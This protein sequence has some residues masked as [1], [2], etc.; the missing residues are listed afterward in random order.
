MTCQTCMHW[1][2][3]NHPSM[4]KHGFGNCNLQE[5]KWVFFPLQHMCSSHKGASAEIVVKREAYFRGKQ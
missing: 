1:N 3:K 4:A 5:N 2:L